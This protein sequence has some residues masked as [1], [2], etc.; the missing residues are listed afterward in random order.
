MDENKILNKKGFNLPHLEEQLKL[1]FP[2]GTIMSAKEK[3]LKVH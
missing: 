1:F 3:K 2:W